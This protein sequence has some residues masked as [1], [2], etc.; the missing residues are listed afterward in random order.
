MRGSW[1]QGVVGV[2]VLGALASGCGSATTEQSGPQGPG[3]AAEPSADAAAQPLLTHEIQA[4]EARAGLLRKYAESTGLSVRVEGGVTKVGPFL[5]YFE[6]T[7]LAGLVPGARAV[8]LETYDEPAS[9]VPFIKLK[10]AAGRTPGYVGT[11]RA[12]G[13]RFALVTWERDQDQT[14]QELYQ[15]HASGPRFLAKLPHAPGLDISSGLLFTKVGEEGTL[16]QVMNHRR[17]GA[18]KSERLVAWR[19]A[20]GTRE[21]LFDV[22]FF[23][24]ELPAPPPPAPAEPAP[25]GSAKPPPAP[26]T[27]PA[28]PLAPPKAPAPEIRAT[29]TR[30]AVEGVGV[31]ITNYAVKLRPLEAAKDVS[32]ALNDWSSELWKDKPQPD[33]VELVEAK[34]TD[35]RSSSLE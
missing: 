2:A 31:Q 13:E 21:V 19:F 3:A 5:S 4:P 15:T 35:Q 27:A 7:W 17:D 30:I 22:P 29:V 9:P 14:E 23:S 20:L 6:A 34:Q 28:P 11:R 25:A 1:R 26:P 33:L 8:R 12:A 16:L 24:L 18:V 10:E 32:L